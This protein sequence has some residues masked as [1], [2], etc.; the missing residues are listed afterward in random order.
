M[1]A[2]ARATLAS[3]FMNAG[4]FWA[5]AT[6]TFSRPPSTCLDGFAAM[7]TP[8]G[9]NK[10]ATLPACEMCTT[11]LHPGYAKQCKTC[12]ANSSHPGALKAIGRT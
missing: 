2:Q 11:A 6:L 8:F 3:R 5:M 10:S 12:C 4:D 9:V 1:A 7:T